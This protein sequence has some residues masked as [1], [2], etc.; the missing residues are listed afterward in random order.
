M[1]E[2][3]E[4]MF[5]ENAAAGELCSGSHQ[6]KNC[7][8]SLAASHGHVGEVNDPLAAVKGLARVLPGFAEL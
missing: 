8:F 2:L 4:H 6:L 3:L 5:H 7:I 1:P